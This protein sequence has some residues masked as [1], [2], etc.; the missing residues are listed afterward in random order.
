MQLFYQ[1]QTNTKMRTP[2]I[3]HAYHLFLKFFLKKLATIYFVFAGVCATA[4]T[5]MIPVNGTVTDSAQRPLAGATVHIQETKKTTTTDSNGGFVID[6]SVGQTIIISFTGFNIY[7]SVITS[8]KPMLIILRAK[9]NALDEVE[10]VSSGYQFIPKERATGAFTH[11]NNATLNQQVGQDILKRL[12]GVSN[13]LLFNTGKNNSKTGI[14]IRGLSTINGT[15]DPLIVLDGFI[16]EGDIANINPNDVESVTLLKDAAAASIWG[17]KA[18]NGVIVITTKKGRFNQDL[19][20][21]FNNVFSIKS[22]PDLYS[23]PLM[24]S[25]DYIDIE[26]ILFN[27]GYFDDRIVWEP[28]RALSPAVEIFLQQRQQLISDADAT[29]AIDRLKTIDL[30]KQYRDNIFKA[31]LLQQYS[32]N[33]RGGSAKHAYIVAVAYDHNRTALNERYQKINIRTENIFRPVKNLSVSIGAYYTNNSGKS[34]FPDYSA[35]SVDG[36]KVPYLELSDASGNPLAIDHMRRRAFT[37]TAVNGLLSDWKYY[38]MEDYLHATENNRLNHL[39]SNIGVQYKVSSFLSMDIRYQH[40]EQQREQEFHYDEKS[41][42]ARDMINNFSQVDPVTRIVNYIIPKGGIRTL[43]NSFVN[44]STLRG[45]LNIFPSWNDHSVNAI[46]G[47][48]SREADYASSSYSAYGYQQDPLTSTPV[49]FRNYYPTIVSWEQVIPGAPTFSRKLD[50]FI[51]FYGNAS[52]SY[53]NKYIVSFSGRKDG[54]NLF[55]TNTNDKW[56]PLWSAGFVWHIS[57]EN[58]YHVKWMNDLRLRSSYGYSGNIDLSK[59]SMATGNYSGASPLT[60]L[61]FARITTLNNPD[62]RWEKIGQLNIGVDFIVLKGRISGSIAYYRKNGTDLYGPAPID[63]TGWGVSGQVVKNVAGMLGQ[64]ADIQLAGIIINKKFKWNTSLILNTNTD[65]VTDY[66]STNAN[67]LTLKLGAANGI[68]PVIGKR[69]YSIAAYKWGGLDQQGNPQGYL[70]GE[71]STDYL[72]IQQQA[73]TSKGTDGVVFLGSSVPSVFGAWNNSFQW[74]QFT[75]SANLVY[76]LGYYFQKT[77]YTTFGLMMGS[78]H[79]DYYKRWKQPGDEIK[80]NIPSFAYPFINGRDAFYSSS[81]ATILRADHIRLQY[82]NLSYQLRS[83]K[84]ALLSG[85]QLYVNVADI[86][87]IWRANKENIDPDYSSSIHPPRTWAIGIRT[88]F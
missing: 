21:E 18:G 26:R 46:I 53:K 57:A 66:Y 45:Q 37:D 12:E 40:E 15:L 41:F 16:Y 43:N 34:G 32:L 75:V 39:F 9:I 27:H 67:D 65:K 2:T 71:L 64:G 48:E 70:N 69:L 7:R 60:N 47:A 5:T 13:G 87:I 17:A 31:P 52:Y 82:I 61:Q 24:E 10:V 50:R 38:P 58:F 28:F 85:M 79:S 25:S 72:A 42:Y 81:E 68:T 22:K 49:D 35:L 59:T 78:G 6:A 14:S 33:I 36:R 55:G 3:F 8:F 77:S 86:G 51:S 54:A 63:Y 29:K 73:A 88:A 62:L 74:K 80:T 84:I 83:N 4:Q 56:K 11:I 19:S 20:L 23:L 44:S 1:Y 30:R 76:K